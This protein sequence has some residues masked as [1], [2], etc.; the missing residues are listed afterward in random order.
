MQDP[1]LDKW[2]YLLLEGGPAVQVI[3]YQEAL[4]SKSLDDQLRE[5][6]RRRCGRLS[7]ARDHPAD[8]CPAASAQEVDRCLQVIAADVVEVEI[9]ALRR[10]PAQLTDEVTGAVVHGRA[11]PERVSKV[12]RLVG[13]SGGS[14]H[15]RGAAG[16]GQLGC[17][18]A[19][20]AGGGR[21]PDPVAR[22]HLRDFD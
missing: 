6:A 18:R 2:E 14:D 7:V 12:P 11:Q 21:Y 4:E 5:V 9:D 15:E 13:A 22:L 10:D 19:D 3:E 16:L 20:G 1:V 17:H 8:G